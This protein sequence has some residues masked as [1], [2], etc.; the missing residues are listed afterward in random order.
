MTRRTL[1]R[2]AE[3]LSAA[4]S[5]RCYPSFAARHMLGDD[6]WNGFDLA[7]DVTYEMS[8][9]LAITDRLTNDEF[10]AEA[11]C[12]LRTGAFPFAARDGGAG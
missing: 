2:A 7:I 11:E 10:Y 1:E 3:L 9:V 5:N 12:L 4:A 8:G 6:D